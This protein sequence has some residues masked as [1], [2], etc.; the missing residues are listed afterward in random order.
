MV[1]EAHGTGAVGPGGRG[2]V[3]EAGLTGEV[4]VIVGT[5]GKSLGSYGAY[6]CGSRELT[7]YLLNTARPFIFSTALP[8]TVVA[9]ASAALEL[10]IARPRQVDRLASNATVLREAL[11]GEG[12][13]IGPSRTQ[14]VPLLVGDAADAVALCERVLERGVFGQAIR[15]PTVPAG[16]SR[17]RLTVMATHRVG[18]LR[19]AARII[20]VAARELG[21]G[22]NVSHD[23]RAPASPTPLRRAA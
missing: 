14:I 2:A 10:L 4:D 11:A 22:G 12:L 20:G 23:R 9:A 16:T 21:I 13:D 5:L 18:E 8:P 1:D 15:P 19:R 3:A 6:T 17:L 7:A